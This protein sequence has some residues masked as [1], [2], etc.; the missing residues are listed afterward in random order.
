[1]QNMEH[2]SVVC[3][4]SCCSSPRRTLQLFDRAIIFLFTASAYTPWLALPPGIVYPQSPRLF[5]LIF[6]ILFFQNESDLSSCHEEFPGDIK[7]EARTGPSLNCDNLLLSLSNADSS[8][9]WDVYRSCVDSA[10]VDSSI[11]PT[12]PITFP[13][14]SRAEGDFPKL[15]HIALIWGGA[16]FGTV[17]Q[18]VFIERRRTLC[19]AFYLLY[20]AGAYFALAFLSVMNF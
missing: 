2:L 8:A 13:V 18:I 14:A 7:V 16:I 17:A 5:S 15:L 9:D 12:D 1:M 4:R 20:C 11:I 10:R 3:S 19:F 6:R